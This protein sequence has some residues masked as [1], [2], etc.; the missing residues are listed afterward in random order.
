[1]N[2]V[3]Q[4]CLVLVAYSPW[5]FLGLAV[6]PAWFFESS[7]G[8]PVAFLAIYVP[9]IGLLLAR[10]AVSRRARMILVAAIATG[11]LLVPAVILHA[12]PRYLLEPDTTASSG[13][14]LKPW[15][16]SAESVVISGLSVR[17]DPRLEKAKG[18][19]PYQ[20]RLS[21]QFR[22]GE[23]VGPPLGRFDDGYG[24]W[25]DLTQ[26][27]P[28]VVRLV[29]SRGGYAA[30]RW[31]GNQFVLDDSRTAGKSESAR[32]PTRDAVRF[33]S[34]GEGLLLVTPLLCWLLLTLFAR[35]LRADRSQP[36]RRSVVSAVLQGLGIAFVLCIPF[37]PTGPGHEMGP[38]GFV[39]F[40]WACSGVGLFWFAAEMQHGESIWSGGGRA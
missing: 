39:C 5:T 31:D 21:F 9:M 24:N 4:I 27:G 36:T 20:F 17:Y 19:P 2:R 10:P 18:G 6:P 3:A 16:G 7:A 1:M 11:L 35:Q 33:A 28:G 29:D 26:P 22:G 37:S 34:W 40:W 13:I 25:L 12:S 8:L 23:E 32:G 38:I 15:R 30:I 14:V